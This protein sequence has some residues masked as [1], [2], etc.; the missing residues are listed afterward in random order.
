MLLQFKNNITLLQKKTEKSNS[1]AFRK[2]N[3]HVYGPIAE[4]RTAVRK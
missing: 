3:P 4:N 1:R 2:L